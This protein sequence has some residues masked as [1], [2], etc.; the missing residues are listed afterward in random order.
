MCYILVG[1]LFQRKRHI[2][3]FL[4]SL[5]LS[6][7]LTKGMQYPCSQHLNSSSIPGSKSLCFI[8]SPS[9]VSGILSSH[10]PVSALSTDLKRG[11]SQITP[12]SK[13]LG[14]HSS[15][16]HHINRYMA[17]ECSTLITK[18]IYKLASPSDWFVSYSD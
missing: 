16:R 6:Q 17:I 7:S 5:I 15:G 9:S 14:K 12:L 18:T 10:R 8:F 13:H 3:L 1:L 2:Q 4:Q 11:L